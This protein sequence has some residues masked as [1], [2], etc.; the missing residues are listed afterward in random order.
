[1]A[2]SF[3]GRLPAC[4]VHKL[5][6]R[7]SGNRE[8]SDLQGNRICAPHTLQQE[9]IAALRNSSAW[10]SSAFIL[11]YDE[12]GGYFD[13]VAPPQMDA[14]GLSMRVPAWVISPFAKKSHLEPTVYEHTSTLKFIERVFGLP[15][16][17][18]VNHRFDAGTPVGPN[19]QA[20]PS[21]ATLGPPAPPRDGR[22]EIGDLMECFA[23]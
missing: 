8:S 7:R 13:H 2:R 6:P 21:G 23:F 20:A 12:H 14:F 9:V 16:L 22:E 4:G 5:D 11:T 3:P 18:S 10:E 19:Y 17:A 1:M 15:T